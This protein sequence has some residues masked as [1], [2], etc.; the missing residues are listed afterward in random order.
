M[1]WVILAS[2]EYD[3]ENKI[4]QGV[5]YDESIEKKVDLALWLKFYYSWWVDCVYMDLLTVTI[6]EIDS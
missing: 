4:L 6:K 3:K 5:I 2:I 1:H